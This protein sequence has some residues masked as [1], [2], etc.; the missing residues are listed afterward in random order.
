MEPFQ[1]VTSESHEKNFCALASSRET[2]ERPSKGEAGLCLA[3]TARISH[4]VRFRIPASTHE[5]TASG[6]WQEIV[7]FSEIPRGPHR[8]ASQSVE[9]GAA[10][11][12]PNRPP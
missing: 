8:R 6:V 5:I 11:E 12:R 9:A 1:W 3:L 2:A 4:A 7:A 10:I